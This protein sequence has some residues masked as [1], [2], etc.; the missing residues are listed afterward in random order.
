[1][2]KLLFGNPLKS[3][4]EVEEEEAAIEAARIPL[5]FTPSNYLI[6]KPEWHPGMEFSVI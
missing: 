3:N 2:L 6:P 1:M 5:V 4:E